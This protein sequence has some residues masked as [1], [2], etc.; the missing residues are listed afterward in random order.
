VYIIVNK[1]SKKVIGYCNEAIDS[2][3]KLCPPNECGQYNCPDTIKEIV[4]NNVNGQII[5]LNDMNLKYEKVSENCHNRCANCEVAE[6]CSE[7]QDFMFNAC[8][9]KCIDGHYF[10]IVN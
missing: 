10:V 4:L 3:Y 9:D 6:M 5:E 7:D 2:N 8:L 1:K